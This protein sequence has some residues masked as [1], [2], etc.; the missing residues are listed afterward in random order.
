MN[1]PYKHKQNFTESHSLRVSINSINE[2]EKFLYKSLYFD[3]GQPFIF[4]NINFKFDLGKNLLNLHPLRHSSKI[5]STANMFSHIVYYI[6]D[7]CS[8]DE[9]III[10]GVYP[11]RLIF[12]SCIIKGLDFNNS[13]FSENIEFNKC[14][15]DNKCNFDNTTFNKSIEFCESVFKTPILFYRT[16]FINHAIFSECSFYENVLFTYSIFRDNII[17]KGTT[18]HKGFDLSSSINS[19]KYNFFNITLNN[20]KS[21]VNLRNDVLSFVI[22]TVNKKETFRIIKQHFQSN[23]DDLEYVKY[24]KLEK[25]PIF[26][27]CFKN[28][29]ETKICNFWNYFHYSFELFSLSL[30]RV[31]N[32]NRNS[33]LLGILFTIIVGAIFFLFT[34][35]SLPDYYFE[36]NPYNW[37]M[38]IFYKYY[39][40][41]MNPTH[42]FN[43]F[44]NLKPNGCTYFW[45]TLGRIFIGYGIYQTVQAFRKLK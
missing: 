41:F 25:K 16:D 40:D 42:D 5:E 36:L 2:L 15:F 8:F 38:E 29:K 28:L 26:E 43:L 11:K 18:F 30:N 33:Y 37:Q 19:G 4:R 23:G 39:L 34:V 14:T 17:F 45:Q 31:S 21:D 22:P 27:I 24:L 32:N 10:S 9:E 44:N 20:F 7:N 6:F 13:T 35:L 3:S 12:N 1:I